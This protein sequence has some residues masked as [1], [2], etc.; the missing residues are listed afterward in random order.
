[1]TKAEKIAR[2]GALKQG[3]GAINDALKMLPSKWELKAF[4]PKTLLIEERRKMAQELL[5][6]K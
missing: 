2:K 4:N 3:V 1:M 5:S 6:L